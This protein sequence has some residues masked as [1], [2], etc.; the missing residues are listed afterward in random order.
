MSES[1]RAIR[2]Q[3]ISDE[4]GNAA[5]SE[6]QVRKAITQLAD[7]PVAIAGRVSFYLTDSSCSTFC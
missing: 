6:E 7:L 5:I 2:L 4:Q 3:Y 1:E